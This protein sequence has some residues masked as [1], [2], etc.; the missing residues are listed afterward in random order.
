M[1]LESRLARWV[2]VTDLPGLE[3]P[4]RLVVVGRTTVGKTTLVNHLT[5]TTR[6]TGLGGVTCEPASIPDADH[7]WIDTPGID[8]EDRALDVL[9]PLI[10]GA[11]GIVWVVDGLQPVTRTERDVL[12][13]LVPPGLPVAVVVSR[14]DLLGEDLD[15]VL[16]RTRAH[17]TPWS[18]HTVLAANL[19]APRGLDTLRVPRWTAAER[20]ARRDALLAL[21]GPL[22]AARPLDPGSLATLVTFRP[23]VKAWLDRRDARG[24]PVSQQLESFAPEL[25]ALVDE[26]VVRWA[27]DPRLDEA[28]VRLPT[29]PTVPDPSWSTLDSVR[30]AAAGAP[31]TRRELRG[32]GGS[33]VAEAELRL[34]DWRDRFLFDEEASER[35][36]RDV[37]AW[38][39]ELRELGQEDHQG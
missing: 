39:A 31:A 23:A 10:E 34:A 13:I 19:R 26:H 5:G 21:A 38:S 15:G 18:P 29:L 24:L 9:D 32:V 2:E 22:D 28:I 14:A 16:A 17:T 3:R 12:E 33:W 1:E 6:P 37:D 36:A 25:Q 30:L 8:R 27:A 7:V 4:R 35:Y 20:V 11:H